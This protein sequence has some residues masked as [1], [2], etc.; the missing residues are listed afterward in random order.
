M[1]SDPDKYTPRSDRLGLRQGANVFKSFTVGLTGFNKNKNDLIGNDQNEKS[2]R[3]NKDE[4]DDHVS[5]EEKERILRMIE[6]EGSSDDEEDSSEE[7]KAQDDA[8]DGASG[9][10]LKGDADRKGSD[11]GSWCSDTDIL[12]RSL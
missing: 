8:R 6:Q 9:G 2:K 11:S 4:D 10:N 12:N 3:K 1:T 7:M 5:D